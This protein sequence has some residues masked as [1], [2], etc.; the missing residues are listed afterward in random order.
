MLISH[1][2]HSQWADQLH[3]HGGQ[4]PASHP[5]S[6][7]ALCHSRSAALIRAKAWADYHTAKSSYQQTYNEVWASHEALVRAPIGRESYSW[8][9]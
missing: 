3:P 5:S 7:A 9:T 8:L 2:F 1:H 4:R 6:G